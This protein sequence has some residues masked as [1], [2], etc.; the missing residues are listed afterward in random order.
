[1]FLENGKAAELKVAGVVSVYRFDFAEVLNA[2][3]IDEKNVT[4]EDRARNRV[5]G[6]TDG[7]L[8]KLVPTTHVVTG[9]TGTILGY[10]IHHAVELIRNGNTL[11]PAES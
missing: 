1:M 10:D 6:A 2:I 8:Q 5:R 11:G 4:E 9:T 7:S 3:P